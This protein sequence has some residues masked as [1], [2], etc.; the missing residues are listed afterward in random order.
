MMKD[1]FR[2]VL[3]NGIIFGVV[4]FDFDFAVEISD[5]E[6]VVARGVEF[7]L[8]FLNLFRVI[9]KKFARNDTFAFDEDFRVDFLFDGKF[10]VR[11]KQRESV[12]FRG[13]FYA[14]Q[15]GIAALYGKRFR[16]FCKSVR[17]LCSLTN[18]FHNPPDIV[19][20]FVFNNNSINK[21]C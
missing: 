21:G 9:G 12:P 16:Y 20:V 10:Q 5:D 14:V 19:L 18:D 15:N 13:E 8:F 6:G 11:G 17:Q 3:E 1:L 2:N 7:E 4:P